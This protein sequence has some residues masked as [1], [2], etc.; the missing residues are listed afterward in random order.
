[1]SELRIDLLGGVRVYDGD[2]E[3]ALAPFQAALVTIVFAHG[4]ASRPAIARLLWTDE[5]DSRAR[6]RLR[7]LLSAT[8]K[9][10]GF[11][12][13]GT[14]GD[15]VHPAPGV[16]S[17]AAALR[18]A[19]RRDEDLERAAR[20]LQRGPLAGE[21]PGLPDV[22][23]DWCDGTREGWRRA[24]E[25]SARSRWPVH[26]RAGDWVR[27]RDV[28]E[29]MVVLEPADTTW[30]G[31]L[32]SAR[33]RDG[34]A[35][36]AEVAFA[37]YCALL[38]LREAPDPE[39]VTLIEAV[40]AMPGANDVAQAEP[41]PAFVGRSDALEAVAPLF[42]DLKDG[43]SSLAIVTGEAGIGKTRVLEELRRS[44]HMDGVRCLSARGIEFERVI[45]L[46]PIIDALAGV[47]VDHHLTALGEPWRTVVGQV[48]PPGT[49][50]EPVGELPLIQESNLSRRLFDAFSLLLDQIAQ[51]RPTVLFLDDLHWADSTT[52][53]TLRFFVRRTADTPFGVIATI[54]PD[55]VGPRDPCSEFLSG[56]AETVTYRYDLEDLDEV[57]AR[58]LVRDV[59]G[60]SASEEDIEGVI[61]TTG[62]H[63]LYLIEVARDRAEAGQVGEAVV[64]SMPPIPVSLR[65]I[66]LAR[67]TSL[68][69]KARHVSA[70]LAIGA[71][72][73]RLGEIAALTD[74][75]IDDVVSATEE[76]QL[77][78]IVEVERDRVWIT[79]DLFRSAIYL[80]LS[81]PRRA[82]LHR[83][84]ALLLRDRDAPPVDEL[85]THLERAGDGAAAAEYAWLAGERC[86]SQGTVAEAA[87]FYG[88]AARSDTDPERV[89]EA[90][91][92]Q[93]I[94]LHLA[95]DMARAA[96][97]LELAS[98]RLRRLG[99][100]RAAR[101]A[102][103][104]RVE[105][106]AEAGAAE[107]SDL[108]A[109]LDTIREDATLNEDWEAVAL[110]LE[111]GIQMLHG[112][113]DVIGA[114]RALEDCQQIAK[115][116]DASAVANISLALNVV[117]GDP[118]AGL[119]SADLALALTEATDNPH[120]LR[121]LLRAMA[122]KQ[123]R[124]RIVGSDFD[125]LVDEARHRAEAAGDIRVR[126]S[127]ES[128]LAVAALDSGELDRAEH[129]FEQAAKHLGNA[130]MEHAR[131]NHFHNL[132]E[133][134][135]ARDDFGAARSAFL[136]A[137]RHLGPTTPPYAS[138]AVLAG[139]GRCA[140][141]T[142]D[143]GEARRRR[144][145]VAL[146]TLPLRYDPSTIIG[147]EVRFLERLR[148]HRAALELLRGVTGSLEG[149]LELAWLKAVLLQGEKEVLWTRD[150]SSLPQVEAAYA[151]ASELRLTTRERQLGRLLEALRRRRPS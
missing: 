46:N 37:E 40:R 148:E 77:A 6:H 75:S 127:V 135:L 25:Q 147:F 102:D 26:E 110:A 9:R 72:R 31:R 33:G 129:L 104:R 117:F 144:Q 119:A 140:L 88:V 63:P 16:A 20:L 122:V 107:A 66:L 126:F 14:D 113:G 15:S 85:A 131:F 98:V 10:V 94:S 44:A 118:E 133:L 95:R 42:E 138:Q 125:D 53:A 1:M 27:A 51:E 17:D 121:A 124:G 97:V 130:E 22:F 8:R 145:Q 23:A 24:I 106:A 150:C 7:Q 123:L 58:A 62:C 146:P 18:D 105:A 111:T 65:E 69:E 49:L 87:H 48:L 59:M 19:L 21:L 57:D 101:R 4:D 103:V 134:H 11:D 36:A 149:R 43:R 114:T 116:N 137:E 132:G 92:R 90:T 84:M 83:R 56:T 86:L 29:A 128:N 78:R 2:R 99:H 93:G 109:H 68:S 30:V 139:L 54:R 142:G 34:Q 13:F 120:R 52:V 89:A 61:L 81:E 112:L 45:S 5:F 80:E 136:Q 115:R 91:A 108:M 50:A 79:H 74:E 82:T 67:T 96:P 71:G 55:A 141:E 39:V 28:A 32:I 41:P 60:E 100:H 143:L 76:L 47:D 64:P 73:M 151:T 70:L 38:P 3:V 12:L 35:R